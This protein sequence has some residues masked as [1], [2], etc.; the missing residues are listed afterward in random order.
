[1]RTKAF[2]LLSGGI[3]S[4]T[5]LA[6]ALKQFSH[7]SGD[8]VVAVSVNYGQ[9]HVKEIEYAKLL[10]HHYDI[11][12]QMVILGPQPKSNLTDPNGVIPN[13]SYAEMGS[14]ASPSYHHFRNGQF[15]SAIAAHASSQLSDSAPDPDREG[16]IYIGVHA[17]D[18]QN[19]AY[20]DCTPEF[21]GAMANA[22]YIGTYR[23][24]RLK[25]PLLEMSKAKVLEKGNL[26]GVPY[27]LT[28]SCYKGGEYHCGICPTCRARK[29]AFREARMSDPTRYVA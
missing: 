10:A 26:L 2:V 16:V 5:C 17:E 24:I 15:L 14:G 22:I 9:R 19:W 25:A 28:W 18:A 8:S 11:E 13:V 27:H 20:A 1:M 12:H 23:Q 7:K 4:A 21:I 6:I 3:D 29:D